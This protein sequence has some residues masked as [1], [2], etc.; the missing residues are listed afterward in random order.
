MVRYK[1]DTKGCLVI[2]ICMIFV[3]SGFSI[4]LGL[5]IVQGNKTKSWEPV[6]ATVIESRVVSEKDSDGDTMYSAEIRYQ[7]VVDGNTYISDNWY[8]NEGEF[9][10]SARSMMENRV[11]EYPEGST[12]TVYYNPENPSEACIRQGSPI[13][14]RITSIGIALFMIIILG[15]GIYLFKAGKKVKRHDEG[16]NIRIQD[17]GQTARSESR[18]VRSKSKAKSSSEDAEYG[19]IDES[20]DYAES[21]YGADFESENDSDSDYQDDA[22]EFGPSDFN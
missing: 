20:D 18:S 4:F 11:N 12:I 10:T 17:Y 5:I 22:D 8:F 9:Q 14:A 21:D 6:S 3:A 15:I 7:Y 2:A 16:I 1:T 19:K 13:W